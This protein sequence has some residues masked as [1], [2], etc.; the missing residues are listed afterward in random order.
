MDGGFG[1]NIR[2]SV[3]KSIQYGTVTLPADTSLTATATISS[4]DTSK[5][6]LIF[7][8]HSSGITGGHEQAR[9]I[10]TNATTVTAT[11]VAGNS[12]QVI[13]SFCVVEFV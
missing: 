3:I 1:S 8:G 4:V 11:R 10:L 5:A 6:A 9:I 13:V 2:S 12:N 7:L